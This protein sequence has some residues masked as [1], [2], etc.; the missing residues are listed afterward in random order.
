MAIF[1]G[2]SS[3]PVHVHG[4]NGHY[5]MEAVTLWILTQ[6]LQLQLT[7]KRTD[8]NKDKDKVKDKE[9]HR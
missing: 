9:R 6:N 7:R 1:P 2:Y 5:L 4:C 8:T 3:Y